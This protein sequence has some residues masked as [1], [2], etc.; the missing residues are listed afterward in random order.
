MPST[1]VRSMIGTNK[2]WK[3]EVLNEGT[4]RKAE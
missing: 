2:F 3:M 4:G 1:V